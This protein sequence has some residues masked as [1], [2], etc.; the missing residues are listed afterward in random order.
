[1]ST[2]WS[3]SNTAGRVDPSGST[4]RYGGACVDALDRFV[5]DPAGDSASL[6]MLAGRATKRS[7]ASRCAAVPALSRLMVTPAGGVPS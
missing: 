5:A 4:R 3:T 7:S 2:S 1:M 6:H